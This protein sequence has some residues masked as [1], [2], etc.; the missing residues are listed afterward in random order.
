MRAESLV[1]EDVADQ[2]ARRSADQDRVGTR[3]TL[4][5][6]GEVGRVANDGLLACGAFADRL[7]DHDDPAGDADAYGEAG[8]VA[9]GNPSVESRHRVENCEASANRALGIFLLRVRVTEINQD[10]IA[11]ELGDIPIEASD[12]FAHDLLIGAD[13]IAHVLG[14]ELDRQVRRIHQVTEH[15][16]QVAAFG[17]G[18]SRS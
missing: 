8:P 1:G 6:S 16:G 9:S 13:H 12:G 11:H 10:A 2:I 3:E 4:Q 17:A 18:S 7:A 5:P 14:I 15:H